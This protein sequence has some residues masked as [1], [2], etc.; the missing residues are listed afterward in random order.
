MGDWVHDVFVS[1][2]WRDPTMTWVR[3]KFV[4]ALRARDLKVCFDVD[5]FGLG[6]TLVTAIESAVDTSAVTASVFTPEYLD[7]GFTDMEQRMAQHLSADQ[8]EIRWIAVIREPVELSLLD[9]FRLAE[10]MI[11]DAGFDHSIDRLVA[12]IKGVSQGPG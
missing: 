3:S 7:S 9:R 12:A 8:Q 2:R 6:E 10:D 11:D 1:Y 5:C 4:P